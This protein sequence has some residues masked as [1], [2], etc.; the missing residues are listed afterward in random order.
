MPLP[1]DPLELEAAAREHLH[2]AAYNYYAA[3]AGM[4][5][6]LEE[7]VRAWRHWH[8][9]PRVLVDVSNVRTETTVLGTP[10]TM[11]VLTAP[12]AV[13]R[14]AH[15]EGELAV[16]RATAAAGTVHVLSTASS[17]PPEEV[18]ACSQ[19]PRWFQ[20]YT[21]PDRAVTDERVRRAE[22]CGMSAVVLTVDLPTLGIRYRGLGR[23][24]ELPEDDRRVLF[25]LLTTAANP[26]LDWKEVDRIRNRTSL[27]L[28]L[29]GLLHPGDVRRAAEL[30][31]DAI[32]V[33]NHGAR[34]LD[35]A[36]PPALALPGAVAAAGGRLEIYVDGGVRSGAD[37]LRALALGARAVLIG[38]PYLWA[39]ALGGES[40]VLELLERIRAEVLNVLRLAGQCE[41]SSVDS[42]IVAPTA[43]RR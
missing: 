34:Q 15:P 11:P 26:G 23:F 41:A 14:L 43:L 2:E 37:V 28:V 24:D 13:N 30:G 4:E 38:R 39:L 5:T 17:Y 19:A 20:L 6:S 21:A 18:A 25:E 9:L 27:P 40:G 12:C 36:I 1:T 31:V 33:S 35:G 42:D 29:K 8:I 16:A 22:A 7:N 3:G 10:V 32:I